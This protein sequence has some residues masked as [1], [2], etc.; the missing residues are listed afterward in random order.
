[1]SRPSW[2]I[3]KP[4]SLSPFITASAGSFQ[5]VDVNV[6]PGLNV[7]GGDSNGLSVLVNFLA[8]LDKHPGH[9][10]IDGNIICR[11]YRNGGIQLFALFYGSSA[12]KDIIIF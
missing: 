2:G 3:L 7:G 6:F 8:C 5:V 4:A 10:M 1:M 11:P 9:F 12:G